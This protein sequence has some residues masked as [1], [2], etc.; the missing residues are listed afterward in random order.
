MVEILSHK[1]HPNRN[2]T[3]RVPEK[4][5]LFFFSFVLRQL[6]SYGGGEASVKAE[7]RQHIYTYARGDTRVFRRHD[8]T[9]LPHN[10]IIPFISES[11][12]QH[13]RQ[14]IVF[15]YILRQ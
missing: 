12:E 15:Y 7:T 10:K 6:R 2:Y 1:G 13:P 4:F 8:T 3:L 9:V 5:T 14:V 11:L